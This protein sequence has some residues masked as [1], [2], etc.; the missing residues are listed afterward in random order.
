MATAS[1]RRAALR[2][3]ERAL[4]ENLNDATSAQRMAAVSWLLA[5]PACPVCGDTDAETHC[6]CSKEERW[7]AYRMSQ[8]GA[9]T[10]TVSPIEQPATGPALPSATAG[11]CAGVL[12]S[13]AHVLSG[14]WPTLPQARQEPCAWIRPG[15]RHEMVAGPMACCPREE[16]LDVTRTL[17]EISMTNPSPLATYRYRCA[18]VVLCA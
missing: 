14:I 1:L 3:Y 7:A 17:L 10:P 16:L 15:T 8:L 5:H 11:V 6:G 4:P 12:V 13:P 2:D 9:R 18:V